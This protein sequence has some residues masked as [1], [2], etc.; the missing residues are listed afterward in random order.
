MKIFFL[1]HFLFLFTFAK[2]IALNAGIFFPN[3][4]NSKYIELL[5]EISQKKFNKHMSQYHLELKQYKKEVSMIN[6]F[7]K[8]KLNI[9][10]LPGIT[11]LNNKKTIAKDTANVWGVMLDKRKALS[12]YLISN[13]KNT[14]YFENIED[15]KIYALQGVN[16]SVQWFQY[17]YHKR[18]VNKLPKNTIKNIIREKESKIMYKIFFGNKKLGIVSKYNYNLLVEL[19]PQLK[20]HI[21]IIQES[22]LIMTPLL[23]ITNKTIPKK[24]KGFIENIFLDL[25]K[26][27]FAS[28]FASS[29]DVSLYSD[30]REQLKNLY[31]SHLSFDELNAKYK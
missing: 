1:L 31:K 18:V 3:T 26:L 14:D 19:N 7:K 9:I 21:K 11:Y 13:K 24:Y 4:D 22:N 30:I 10:F 29:L 17:L 6:D 28:A 20:K 27:E 2:P 23:M 5:I 25:G 16:Y 12:Y 15:Y 8:N